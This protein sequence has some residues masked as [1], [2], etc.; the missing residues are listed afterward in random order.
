MTCLSPRRIRGLKKACWTKNNRNSLLNFMYMW[1]VIFLIG[2][3]LVCKD[4]AH[5]LQLNEYTLANYLQYVVTVM[6]YCVV[7]PVSFSLQS[8]STHHTA[9]YAMYLRI[10]VLWSHHCEWVCI[11]LT[12]N[13]LNRCFWHFAILILYI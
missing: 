4:E 7:G 8:F 9:M 3:F 12:L 2:L 11:G 1:C 10:T 13:H 5:V 6:P